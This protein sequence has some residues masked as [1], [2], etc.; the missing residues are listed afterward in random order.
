MVFSLTKRPLQKQSNI[1]VK[2]LLFF[3]ILTVF[4][5]SVSKSSIY[6]T[7]VQKSEGPSQ[8]LKIKELQKIVE[9]LCTHRAWDGIK[10]TKLDKMTKLDN[11]RLMKNFIEKIY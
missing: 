7:A 4:A 2:S 8:G 3:Q 9:F 6:N 1:E 10:I 11:F 5:V